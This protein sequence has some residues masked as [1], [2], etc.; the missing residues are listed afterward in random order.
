MDRRRR[1]A[2]AGAVALTLT[3]GVLAFGANLGLF[4]LADHREPVGQISP[5]GAV[6]NQRTEPLPADP[7][8]DPADGRSWQETREHRTEADDDAA[9]DDHAKRGE[10]REH[11]EGWDDD[12]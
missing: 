5:V 11:Q 4:G 8:A 10:D 1:L 6:V 3:S 12:D 9:A 7:A 2:I